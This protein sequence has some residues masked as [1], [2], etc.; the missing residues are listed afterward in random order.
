MFEENP[1]FYIEV[2]RI[3]AGLTDC[4]LPI[5]PFK[6]IIAKYM[7][8]DI[9][10]DDY[11]EEKI[12]KEIKRSNEYKTLK[13]MDLDVVVSVTILDRI[14]SDLVIH[15]TVLVYV[16]NAS[17]IDKIRKKMKK[18]KELEMKAIHR[19]S[20]EYR[21]KV[22]E[23]EGKLL[24]YPE[25]CISN[26]VELKYKSMLG[27]TSPPETKLVMECLENNLLLKVLK[28]FENPD[29]LVDEIYSLFTSNF[30][31]CSIECSKAMDMGKRYEE[32]LEGKYKKAYRCKLVLNALYILLSAYNSYKFMKSPKTEYGQMVFKFFNNLSK[33]E[34][35]KIERINKLVMMDILDFE[36]KYI[37]MH[38]DYY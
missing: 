6:D 22:N 20:I 28:L 37:L 38:L 10:T 12:E 27:L 17:K 8:Y 29:S 26:F 34:I 32:F 2:L 4:V 23:M 33:S 21:L 24:N 9:T 31:P 18:I 5:H 19:R 1:S 13:E 7:I 25:C 16:C 15:P 36:N 11:V 30:Y 14:L 35:N 3:K